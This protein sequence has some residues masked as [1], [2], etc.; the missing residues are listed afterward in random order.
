MDE[1]IYTVKDISGD[2]ATL[3]DEKGGEMFIAIALLPPSV[4]VGTKLRYF[5]FQYEI[6]N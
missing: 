3:V 4:D 1:I 5:M 6:I 2:Y